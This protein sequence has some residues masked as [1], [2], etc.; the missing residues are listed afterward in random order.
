MKTKLYRLA[1][2]GKLGCL[3]RRLLPQ[4]MNPCLASRCIL[5]HFPA[6]QI[7]RDGP[8][9]RALMMHDASM[10]ERVRRLVSQVLAQ[11]GRA[12]SDEIRETILIR[13]GYYCGRR[14]ETDVGAA[15]WFVEENQV[16]VFRADGSMAQVLDAD[17][18]LHER[19]AAA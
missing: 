4:R 16:K 19:R 5:R 11:I 6:G 12:D 10:T 14:F 17:G 3:W 9:T 8:P 7:A 2:R 18:Q 13:D 1:R 15:I